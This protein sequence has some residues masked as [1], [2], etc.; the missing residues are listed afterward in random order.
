MQ[1][2]QVTPAD[3]VD[4]ARRLLGVTDIPSPPVEAPLRQI[5]EREAF[6][7]SNLS[8]E[9]TFEVAAVLRTVGEHSYLWVEEDASVPDDAL[10]ALAQTFDDVIYPEVRKLWGSESTPGIDGDPR[11]YGLFTPNLGD[12][13]IAYYA[14]RHSYPDEVIAYSNEHEMM[15]FN[16]DTIGINLTGVE[17]TLAHEFQHMI[18]ATIDPNEDTWLDEGFSK[19]T[20][21]Y[22]G[23]GD[24]LGV[25]QDFAFAPGTQLNTWAYDSSNG[26]HYG[27]AMLFVTYFYERYGLEAIQALSADPVNGLASFDTILRGLGEPGVDVFFADWVLANVIQNSALEDGRYGYAGDVLNTRVLA[28][29]NAYP[30]L[31]AG[32]VNQYGTDSYEFD[33]PDEATALT[34]TLTAPQ[35]VSLVPASAASGQQVWYSN[36]AD[37]SELNLTRVFDLSG[38]QAA[39]LTYQAWYQIEPDWDYAY[40]MVSVDDG[41]HWDI[42]NASNMTTAN[43]HGNAYGTGYSGDSGG[44]IQNIVSLDA[45]AGQSNV[46]VRFSLITDDAISLAGMMIDDVAIPE[47]EYFGDFESGEEGWQPQGWIWMDNVLPQHVWVQVIQ[48]VGDDVTVTRWRSPTDAIESLTLIDGVEKV[49]LTITPFAPVTT[50]PMP[51]TLTVNAQ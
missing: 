29:I 48:F 38:V 21:Y 50:V 8:E 17:S 1:N 39:T 37:A 27:A 3:R 47:I 42:L 25:G 4:L 23:Y 45:Y 13:T 2:A 43:P 9:Q 24:V 32:T 33:V 41:A 10:L 7:A 51:Y 30:Y 36:R 18:R 26:V 34:L 15:F 46:Q 19:F 16:L 44:W 11:I 31:A 49:I 12:G 14:G 6:W 22:L 40:V 5:G 20:E 28:S 35:T